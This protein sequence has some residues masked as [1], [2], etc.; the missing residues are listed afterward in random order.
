MKKYDELQQSLFLEMF[1]DP[2][3]NEM[4]WEVRKVENVAT[5]KKHSIKAGPFGSSLKKEFYVKKGYKI[6][7]QEQ[8]I[9][10]DLT[11]GDYYIDEEKYK[12]LE[13]CSVNSGDVL[14]SLVGTY[15]KV[16]VIPEHFEAGIINP[17][18]MK[19]SPNFDLIRSDFLKKILQSDYVKTQMKSYT[20]GGT[21][22]IINVGIV[23]KLNIPL[24][25]LSLQN[26]FASRIASIE[27]QKEQVKEAL[28]KS[29]EVFEGLLQE[30]FG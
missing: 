23:K 5:S 2:V 11:F 25:P 8:V 18:L 19:I 13:S 24:P 30:R 1:G 20:R 3:L 16:A 4:G 15:G 17:R 28:V 14:V 21:M 22:D 29:E 26:E 12:E 7:G 27:L 10:N 9:K 6:Y